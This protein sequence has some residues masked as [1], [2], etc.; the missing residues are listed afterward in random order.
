[1]ES[2]V[3]DSRNPASVWAGFAAQG[4]YHSTDGGTTWSS[5]GDLFSS[6]TVQTIAVSP[7]SSDVVYVGTD[8]SLY[9]SIDGGDSWNSLGGVAPAA[10][11]ITALAISP[12]NP[13]RVYAATYDGVYYSS[14]GGS[15][16]HSDTTDFQTGGTVNTLLADPANPLAAYAGT[17]N[18]LMRTTDGGATWYD[19][20][21]GDLSYDHNVTALALAT[22]V[23]T[24]ADP[25]GPACCGAQY[26]PQKQHNLQGLFLAFY[27]RYGGLDTF[28]YPRTEEFMENGV[29]MQYTERFLLEDVAG[30]VVPAALGRALTAGRGFPRVAPF[31]ATASRLYFASTGHTLSGAFLRYWRTH[32]G[33]I[34][35]GAP[36][37]EPDHEMN[38]DGTGR[39]YLIQWFENGRL[40]YHPELAGTR[41]AVEIGLCGKQDLQRRGWLS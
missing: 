5:V 30:H 7:A 2:V 36:I 28:G 16:W 38:G 27:R 14:D 8:S 10:Q 11:G 33:T 32:H 29:V 23:H 12:R 39:T 9:Q 40:E 13:S 3:V 20:S 26:F 37:A 19:A 24:P 17:A 6:A 4:L 35:L 34:L 1:V 31:P 21:G 18:D 41:Y 25:V 15:T 22:V